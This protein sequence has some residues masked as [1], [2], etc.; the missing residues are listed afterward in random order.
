M[1][2]DWQRLQREAER[3]HL[4][5]HVEVVEALNLCPWAKDARIGGRV[6]LCVSALSEPD[7]A[8]A[9]NAIEA[10]MT[11]AHTQIGILV[12][13][14]L[15]LERIAFAHFVAAVREHEAKDARTAAERIALADFHPEATPPAASFA[16]RPDALDDS[17]AERLV[18]FFRRAPDPMIQ[19]VRQSALD[20]VRLSEDHGTSFVDPTQ[21]N[22]STIMELPAPTPALATRVARNNARTLERVGLER[23]QL[24]LSDIVR[25]RNVSYAA[26]GLEQ[27]LWAL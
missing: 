5:Y 26:L 24:L 14:L 4:R 7:S 25:D 8:A 3:V 1:A 11:A 18:P 2:L 9:W 21:Y 27:P 13:P 12:F 22:L 17:S 20:D 10:A 16:Q 15:A 6:R 23:V 19:I